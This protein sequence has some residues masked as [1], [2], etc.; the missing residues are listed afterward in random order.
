MHSLFI[1]SIF[2][3]WTVIISFPLMNTGDFNPHFVTVDFNHHFDSFIHHLGLKLSIL[4]INRFISHDSII[5]NAI[6][7]TYRS[8]YSQHHCI[9]KQTN[10]IV[11]QTTFI[12]SILENTYLHICL[13]NCIPSNKP[14]YHH[15]K[16]LSII[17]SEWNTHSYPRSLLTRY[18][19]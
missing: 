4:I 2:I 15:I 17:L 3:L 7:I 9:I 11:K 1:T 5:C 14:I 16:R 6:Y 12:V 13:N 18:L 8:Q 19:Q 10:H